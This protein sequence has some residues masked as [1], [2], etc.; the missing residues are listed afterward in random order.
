MGNRASQTRVDDFIEKPS[1]EEAPS[2]LAFAG[3]YVF[4]PDIFDYLAQA[5]PGK[6]DEIQLTDALRLQCDQDA[7]YGYHYEGKRYDVGNRADYLIT[8]LEFALR[9]PDLHDDIVPHLRRLVAEL[10]D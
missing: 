6:N 7:A 1:I 2:R 10:E 3:R 9:R 8:Q 5:K 4:Q